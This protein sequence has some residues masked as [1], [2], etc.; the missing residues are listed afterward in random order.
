MNIAESNAWC[1]VLRSLETAASETDRERGTRSAQ[2][3]TERANAAL[4]AGPRPP[5]IASLITDVHVAV[6]LATEQGVA[7]QLPPIPVTT[8]QTTGEFL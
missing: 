3:L 8:A 7:V 1:H 4:H 2:F 6:D 5:Q